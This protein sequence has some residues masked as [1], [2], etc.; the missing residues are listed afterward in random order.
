[1]QVVPFAC[2]HVTTTRVSGSRRPSESLAALAGGGCHAAQPPRVLGQ[3]RHDE[4]RFA[5]L[6]RAQHVRLVTVL[7]HE[8]RIIADGPRVDCSWSFRRGV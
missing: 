7:P 8:A 4:V 3:E 1:V 6:G 5:E 2:A